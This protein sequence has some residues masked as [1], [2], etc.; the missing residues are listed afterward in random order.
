M[1]VFPSFPRISRRW[2]VPMLSALT[3][4]SIYAGVFIIDFCIQFVLH[5]GNPFENGEVVNS[6]AGALA[7]G[8][9]NML[10]WWLFTLVPGPTTL[11]RATLAGALCGLAAPSLLAIVNFFF[12]WLVRGYFLNYQGRPST[13]WAEASWPLGSVPIISIIFFVWLTLPICIL[14]DR[15]MAKQ[16]AP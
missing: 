9:L 12:S 7:I 15:R 13:N 10:L 16:L 5:W 3:A 6:I 14:L 1:L 11:L 8:L 2:S 4:L